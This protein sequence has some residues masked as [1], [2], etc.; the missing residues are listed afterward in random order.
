MKKNILVL[1]TVI[2]TFF[3]AQAMATN[4]LKGQFKERYPDYKVV[5]CK[6]CHEA[7][8]KLNTYGLDLQKNLLNFEIIEQLDSDGDAFTNIV[9]IKANTLPGDKT[10]APKE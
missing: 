6:V 4:A 2:S 9:E 1:S 5:N 8:P 10:S 3:G 7:Q